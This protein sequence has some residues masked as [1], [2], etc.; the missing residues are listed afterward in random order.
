MEAIA[1]DNDGMISKIDPMAGEIS[2]VTYMVKCSDISSYTIEESV[3]VDQAQNVISRW[4]YEVELTPVP[5]L[6]G[7]QIDYHCHAYEDLRRLNRDMLSAVRSCRSLDDEKNF[8]EIVERFKENFSSLHRALSKLVMFLN[9][10]GRS[11]LDDVKERL[12]N[13]TNEF[14]S[15]VHEHNNLLFV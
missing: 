11:S 13:I 1:T 7:G 10:G 5:N 2:L 15:L 12:N 9:T 4:R 14:R 8:G 6:S 3:T